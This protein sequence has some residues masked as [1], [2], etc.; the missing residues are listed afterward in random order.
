MLV[1]AN[2][3]TALEKLRKLRKLKYTER[4]IE[5]K[6]EIVTEF[7]FKSWLKFKLTSNLIWHWIQLNLKLD[8][9]WHSIYLRLNVSW[10]WT[11]I[12]FICMIDGI[13]QGSTCKKLLFDWRHIS[14]ISVVV[15]KNCNYW[16]WGQTGVRMRGDCWS[17]INISFMKSHQ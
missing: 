11:S 14:L 6:A 1:L 4:L 9:I 12:K 8:N 2:Q 13:Y 16:H 15:V 7:D 5:W 17:S 10:H 3:V